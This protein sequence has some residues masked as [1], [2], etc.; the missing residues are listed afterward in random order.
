MSKKILILSVSAVVAIILAG[1]AVKISLEEKILV[2][3]DSSV[4]RHLISIAMSSSRPG[5]EK[6]NVCYIPYELAV[7]TGDTVTWINE[8]SAFHTVTSGYY[9]VH[10]GLFES[11][12]MD[13]MQKFS[14]Q[15]DNIGDFHY[16]CRLHPWMEG[17]ISVS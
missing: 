3:D 8:D 12:Q 11:G 1:V 5:C 15:F 7:N 9:D 10:D 2:V 13:P 17:Q 4:D 16:Y 6:T 14:Y